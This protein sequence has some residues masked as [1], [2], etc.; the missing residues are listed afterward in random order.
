MFPLSFFAFTISIFKAHTDRS[1]EWK[2]K[3][4]IE[5]IRKKDSFLGISE[6]AFNITISF[7]P[8]HV[9]ILNLKINELLTKDQG[10]KLKQ[11]LD[12]FKDSYVERLMRSHYGLNQNMKLALDFLNGF[13]A[14]IKT[15]NCFKWFFLGVIPKK[16]GE[17]PVSW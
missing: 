8:V 14:W 17:A 11:E 3:K 1:L 9:F 7:K 16:N 10:F 15:F 2:E 13:F 6:T 12:D 4:N 5:R